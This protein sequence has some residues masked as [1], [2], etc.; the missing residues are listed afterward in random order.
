MLNDIF[1]TYCIML[2]INMSVKCIQFQSIPL[3][4]TQML[5]VSKKQHEYL[6][7]RLSKKEYKSTLMFGNVVRY[8]L[9]IFY[10]ND[11]IN[12]KCI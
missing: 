6:D 7:F 12:V 1:Y 2:D 3:I 8:T 5:N 9:N 4:H 10:S 11:N